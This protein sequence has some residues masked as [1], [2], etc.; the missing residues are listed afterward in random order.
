MS[1][2]SWV[3]K[4]VF[5]MQT[6]NKFCL[7]QIYIMCRMFVMKKLILFLSTLSI[8]SAGLISCGQSY[9]KYEISYKSAVDDLHTLSYKSFA[10]KMNDKENGEGFVLCIYSS[11][12]PSCSCWTEFRNYLKYHYIPDTNALFYVI[13]TGEFSGQETYGVNINAA[14]P[15]LCFFNKGKLI[16]QFNYNEHKSIFQSTTYSE[17]K[18]LMDDYVTQQNNLFLYPDYQS[19]TAGIITK[20]QAI[21]Y[22]FKTSC[23]DCKSAGTEVLFP[24][25][26]GKDLT[27]K[28]YL[29]DIDKYAG[30]EE[31]ASIKEKLW[32]TSK[33][34]DFGYVDGRVPTFQYWEDGAIVDACVYLNDF[35]AKDTETGIYTISDSFFTAERQSSLSYL[36]DVETTVLK[37]K[38]IP[39]DQVIE[40]GGEYYWKTAN[41]VVYHKPLLQ[42]FINKYAK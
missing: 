10:Q 27:C 17:F 4:N 24:Y 36:E 40:Y 20:E 5:K 18:R 23:G 22:P 16:K 26:K 33:T 38:E 29:V 13:G 19:A 34:K 42:A 25:L 35:I 2:F 37:G 28:I 9:T 12:S 8:L 7:Q 14:M 15:S 32:M 3:F 11:L 30:T 1:F 6:S 21:F 41:A 31:Y 39:S